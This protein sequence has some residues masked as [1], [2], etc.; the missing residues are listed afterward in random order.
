MIMIF[1]DNDWRFSEYLIPMKDESHSEIFD[2]SIQTWVYYLDGNNHGKVPAIVEP[3]LI[4]IWGGE[5]YIRSLG[6]HKY[7]NV[8][9]DEN[10]NEFTFGNRASY[11]N[12]P[13]PEDQ[14]MAHIFPVIDI[15]LLQQL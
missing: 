4:N 13:L 8:F 3:N 5:E 7:W 12:S 1:R 6:Y 10:S 15:N 14:H 9:L 2:I 11:A